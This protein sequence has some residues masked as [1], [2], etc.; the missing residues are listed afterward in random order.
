[1]KI[2]TSLALTAFASV[3]LA[4][5][6]STDDTIEKSF[7]ADLVQTPH[8]KYIINGESDQP[9]SQKTRLEYLAKAPYRAVFPSKGFRRMYNKRNIMSSPHVASLIAQKPTFK[10]KDGSITSLTADNFP[11]LK[12]LSIRRLLL[13][14]KSVRE[15]HWYANSNELAYCLRGELLVTIF[16]NDN[17]FNRFTISAGQMFYVPSGALH[18]LENAGEKEAEVIFAFTHERPEDFG[19]S[20]A[21]GAMSDAVLGN[22]Y[23]L[24]AKSFEAF[25]RTTHD[26][27]I[28]HRQSV[29]SIPTEARWGNPHKLDIEATLGSI[30]SLAGSAK[31]ARKQFWPI[32]D[33]IS[34]Y[35][36]RVT[37][38]G[39]R[40]PHW[41]PTTA[42][43][44]Y[45]AKGHARITVMN[46]GGG[47][48]TFLL[49]TGDVYFIPSAYPHHIENIG[50]GDIHFLIFFDQN[51]PGDIGY[52][53]ST[54]GYS[55]DTLTAAFKIDPQNLPVLPFTV[56]DPSII[57]RINP[58]DK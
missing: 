47:L 13:E 57:E 5:G 40:E 8:Q 31:T 21:F 48:D 58:I 18:H 28:G 36:V 54:S 11:I 22:T 16:E 55:R 53:A 14:P 30:S 51:T 41:H 27:V 46:P 12:R 45:V 34:M 43:M 20:S 38:Q 52:K 25:N 49:K 56:K 15:P 26:T 44:A 1:M 29:P 39:M 33:D 37:D 2:S 23:N 4:Q 42:E 6:G 17:K 7:P 3:I 35:S 24:P 19:L 50:Q 9:N 32:L 10:S